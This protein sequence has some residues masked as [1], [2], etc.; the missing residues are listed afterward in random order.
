[1]EGTKTRPESSEAKANWPQ[2]AQ[3]TSVLCDKVK[4]IE[5]DQLKS[6]IILDDLA[7]KLAKLQIETGV[8]TG[9]I[10]ASHSLHSSD[11]DARVQRST[12]VHQE[13]NHHAGAS[14]RGD[15]R[16]PD[17]LSTTACN[18]TSSSLTEDKGL[19]KTR[20]KQTDGQSQHKGSFE[21]KKPQLQ[22]DRSTLCV[23]KDKIPNKT[24]NR[25]APVSLQTSNSVVSAGKVQTSP[26]SVKATSGR[27][28]ER[29]GL[30][31]T[32]TQCSLAPAN[33]VDGK[34]VPY[35]N[36]CRMSHAKCEETLKKVNPYQSKLA[37]TTPDR[38]NGK[39]SET[40]GSTFLE[41]R[42]S[43][44]RKSIA[45]APP[46]AGRGVQHR[47][48]S[49]KA[50]FANL[51][52]STN[53]SEVKSSES[54]VQPQAVFQSEVGSNA[55]QQLQCRERKNSGSVAASYQTAIPANYS[56][57]PSS[58][59]NVQSAQNGTKSCQK[60]PEHCLKANTPTNPAY[61]VSVQAEPLFS[62][63]SIT[64]DI[65]SKK[66]LH[67][68]RHADGLNLL[69][70]VVDE[71]H[72]ITQGLLTTKEVSPVKQEKNFLGNLKN[73]MS[74][75]FSTKKGKKGGDGKKYVGAGK[76]PSSPVMSPKTSP[77][78]SPTSQTN[79]KMSSQVAE[80][81]SHGMKQ[82]SAGAIEQSPGTSQLSSSQPDND[83]RIGLT[84]LNQLPKVTATPS[85][86]T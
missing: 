74:S 64:S 45:T 82:P 24:V 81:T 25:G 69:S 37:T 44:F 79:S 49:N 18:D 73:K 8:H 10:V 36:G 72:D 1:M 38:A 67:G 63:K 70:D 17:E 32:Q 20:L 65:R 11:K 15:Y 9:K 66:A 47:E 14:E 4:Q 53:V 83:S 16:K 22:F 28:N 21:L 56:S 41:G 61:Q 84:S 85:L 80:A 46:A 33:A 77:G 39:P 27:K 3:D 75:V 23:Q 35:N 5:E 26:S 86:T 29:T 42:D 7:T 48:L 62:T 30:N 54:A 76:C 40:K 50:R 58:S 31:R 57:S 6:T 34:A 51:N 52:N 68:T 19:K 13:Q 59:R 55:K 12:S 43:Q 71:E 2:L 78:A 60:K